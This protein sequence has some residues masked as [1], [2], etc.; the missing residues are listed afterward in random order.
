MIRQPFL[1]PSAS[2]SEL[3]DYFWMRTRKYNNRYGKHQ[4]YRCLRKQPQT[5]IIRNTQEADHNLHRGFRFRKIFFSIGHDRGQLTPGTERDVSQLR[6]AIPA[7]IRPA[8]C[9]PDR[10]SPGSYR[11]RPEE[12]RPERPFDG[13]DLYGHLFAAPPAVLAG[14]QTVCRILRHLLFQSSA[15]A[16]PALRRIGRGARTG[17]P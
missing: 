12:A 10:A 3:Y 17:H 2:G 16:M 15:G 11:D 8:A 5:Y 7:Q 4:S 13:R 6:P 9:G 1:Y 14:R